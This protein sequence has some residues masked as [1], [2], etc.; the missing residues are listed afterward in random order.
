MD[1]QTPLGTT[2]ADFIA[3]ER[4]NDGPSQP[5]SVGVG[6]AVARSLARAMRGEIDV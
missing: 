5:A 3:Y 2:G 1:R 4:A 6:L